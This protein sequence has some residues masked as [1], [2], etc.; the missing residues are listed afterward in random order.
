MRRLTTIILLCILAL[1]LSLMWFYARQS[2]SEKTISENKNFHSSM[3]Y[4]DNSDFFIQSVKS[5]ENVKPLSPAPRIFIVNQH[6]LAAHIIAGQFA[7]SA[8]PKVKTVVLITQNNWN[9]GRAPIIT[10][11]YGWKTPLGTIQPA[12]KL[13][14]SLIEKGLVVE[15]VD[16]FSKEHGITGIVPYVAHSFPNATIIPLV[17]RDNAPN[18]IID[19]LAN[20]LSRLNFSQTVIV[21]TIDMSHY[22]P[23][24]ISDAHDRLTVQTIK[25]FDYE[26]LPRLDIDTVPTLRTV[27]KVA[28]SAGEKSFI[29]TGGINSADIV[30]DPDLMETTGYVS[31]YFKKG[32]SEKIDG[33]VHLLFVGDIMLDRAIA[34]HAR[35]YGVDSLFAKVER[36]F[37]GTHAVIGN[38]EGTITDK[39]SISEKDTSI[40]RFT[41]DPKFATLL[42]KLHFTTLSL[43]N[44]H[45]LDFGKDG[46]DQTKNNLHGANIT[47]FGSPQNND[48]ASVRL[49]VQGKTICLVGYHDLFTPD[50]TP[51]LEEIKNIKSSC[52]HI[53]LFAHWGIEYS[54]KASERQKMLAHKFIDAGADLIIGSHPHV[55]QP[56]EIYKNKAIFYSLGNFIF[57]Q[58]FSVETKQ[59][60]T[61]HVEWGDEKMRFT[62][63][64]IS[65]E[66]GEVKIAEPFIRDRVISA[67]VDKYLLDNITS[68]IMKKQEFTLWNQPN[69]N[70]Q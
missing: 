39:P 26:T 52:S 7:L 8:D 6:I 50:P 60:L 34:Q 17:I 29:Q 27:L 11:R 33:D 31:G 45:A 3:Y 43:A 18:T 13:T 12:N 22:L 54:P 62:L 5:F 58:N 2:E 21:G 59:G 67:L 49:S 35:K 32:N 23:K 36:L 46:Y 47:T 51:A 1:F 16:I 19:A 56:I 41:F 14:N 61:V 28:E 37:L 24:Y 57:D 70:N 55:V 38:L 42:K 4:Y 65:I 10:S 25:Q 64:P 69:P 30:G 15:E 66:R 9:A 48:N 63:V 20:E 68:D 53:V 44:N 40:L